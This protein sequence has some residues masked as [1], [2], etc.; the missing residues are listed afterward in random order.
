MHFALQIAAVSGGTSGPLEWGPDVWTVVTKVSTP[1]SLLA[2]CSTLVAI[3]L[4]IFVERKSRLEALTPEDQARVV[5]KEL[6]AVNVPIENLTKEQRFALVQQQLNSRVATLSLVVRW[7]VAAFVLVFAIACLAFVATNS[8][9]A[10]ETAGAQRVKELEARNSALEN[11]LSESKL[12]ATVGAEIAFRRNEAHR[13]LEALKDE[14]NATLAKLRVPNPAWP[15]LSSIATQ[16]SNAASLS[17]L[18]LFGTLEAST[19]PR[20]RAA[21]SADH[22]WF[23]RT[24]F[25]DLG[26]CA[27]AMIY[28][29]AQG[30]DK[31]VVPSILEMLA[32]GGDL[33]IALRQLGEASLQAPGEPRVFPPPDLD[34]AHARQFLENVIIAATQCSEALAKLEDQEF[35]R[36]S[37]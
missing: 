33:S 29:R 9:Q 23:K 2:F 27:L 20:R 19:L 18:L 37:K 7:C 13:Q 12:D 36:N 5:E 6:E 16:T 3:V 25:R 34:L 32:R 14:T 21:G 15:D 4:R 26:I 10:T 17:T 35:L 11:E 30:N 31:D 24:E 8:V 28:S 1:V 22:S